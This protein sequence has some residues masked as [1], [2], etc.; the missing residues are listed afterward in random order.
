MLCWVDVVVINE[1]K[2]VSIGRHRVWSVSR[3][4]CAVNIH[5]S[6]HA[7]EFLTPVSTEWYCHCWLL[8]M[9][10]S[11]GCGVIPESFG[12][13]HVAE[14]H[15]DWCVLETQDSLC[16]E[17]FLLLWLMMLNTSVVWV[18]D[19]QL[20]RVLPSDQAWTADPILASNT[21]SKP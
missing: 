11:P 9:I 15:L 12:F 6:G 3:P 17:I 10:R 8:F 7:A 20:Q 18:N 16:C 4:I 2:I 19:T 14:T 1:A 13:C 5:S 21:D